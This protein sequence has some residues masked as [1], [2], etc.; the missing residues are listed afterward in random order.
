MTYSLPSSQLLLLLPPQSPY[1]ICDHSALNPMFVVVCHTQKPA[2]AQ[3]LSLTYS[4]ALIHRC[5]GRPYLRRYTLFRRTIDSLGDLELDA[6]C[7]TK[8]KKVLSSNSQIV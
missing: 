4:L 5:I 6:V 1:G 7:G 3:S 8:T 2:T